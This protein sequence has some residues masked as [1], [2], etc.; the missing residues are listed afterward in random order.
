[1]NPSDT[2]A[3]PKRLSARVLFVA[4][5]LLLLGGGAAIWGL[6]TRA[7]ALADVSLETR[8]AAVPT[9]A[10]VKPEREASATDIAL[11]G[12]MQPFAEAPIYARTSGYL[13]K[14]Y[15]DIGAHVRA[16]QVLADIDT[17]EVDQQ[18]QQGRADLSV[19]E[20]NAKLAQSHRRALRTQPEPACL[21]AGSRYRHRI[22][23]EDRGGGIG[24][25]TSSASKS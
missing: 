3:Q 19:A 10:V 5:L 9:V 23:R 25:P 12:T 7:H 21:E 22:R 17:P 13:R 20:A 8:E 1:M 11:P 2:P 6:S 4:F 24:A 16:G 14:W 18:L 15:V